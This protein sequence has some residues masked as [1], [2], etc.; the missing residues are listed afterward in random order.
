[1]YHEE[2]SSDSYSHS[3]THNLTTSAPQ[4]FAETLMKGPQGY[5]EIRKAVRTYSNFHKLIKS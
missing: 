5:V 2:P 1:M 4:T 3:D